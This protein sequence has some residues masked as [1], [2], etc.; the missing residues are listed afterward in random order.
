MGVVSG[1]ES[2]RGEIPFVTV[3]KGFASGIRERRLVVVRNGR[4]WHDVWVAHQGVGLPPAAAPRIDF[5]KEMVIAV[6]AGEKATGGHVIEIKTLE[7]TSGGLR[8]FYAE[9][10]SP[11]GAMVGQVLTQPYHIVR[12]RRVDGQVLFVQLPQRE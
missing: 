2:A 11:A 9:M 10:R 8:V 3:D 6:F 5:D 1:S 7:G 4:E 12:S